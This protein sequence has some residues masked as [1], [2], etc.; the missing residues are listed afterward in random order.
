M[1]YAAGTHRF[2][3]A[4]YTVSVARRTGNRNVEAGFGYLMDLREP[5]YK[6]I[7]D[8]LVAV[9]TG[10]ASRCRRGRRGCA[11]GPTSSAT[12]MSSSTRIGWATSRWKS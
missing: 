12:R 11:A 4:G 3:G 1:G 10:S 9:A 2:W 8:L 5:W 7:S 6:G